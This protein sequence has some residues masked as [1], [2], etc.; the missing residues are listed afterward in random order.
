MTVIKELAIPEANIKTRWEEP[1]VSSAINRI[2]SALPRGVY[3]GFEVTQKATPGSGVK[4]NILAGR[5][6]FLLHQDI[7]GGHKTSVRYAVD[8]EVDFTVSLFTPGTTYF[9][10]VDVTYAVLS[11]TVGAIF[12]GEAADLASAPN[13]VPI[14]RFNSADA[15]ITNAEIWSS[16]SAT[17]APA[18]PS[19]FL[20]PHP[21][22]SEDNPYGFINELEYLRLPTQDQKDAMDGAASPSA[23]NPFATEDGLNKGAFSYV[24]SDGTV[25]HDGDFDGVNALIQALDAVESDGGGAIYV[26]RGNYTL[27]G[28]PGKTYTKPI[29][30]YCEG[31]PGTPSSNRCLLTLDHTNSVYGLTFTGMVDIRHLEIVRGAA[32][33]LAVSFQDKVF[34]E[35]LIVSGG[36]VQYIGCTG[37]VTGGLVDECSI[38]GIPLPGLDIN[39]VSYVASGGT[40]VTVQGNC[41]GATFSGCVFDGTNGGTSNGG[42]ISQ[43]GGSGFSQGS[44]SQ[45]TFYSRGDFA[46]MSIGNTIANSSFRDCVV[47]IFTPR[48]GA[49]D[50]ASFKLVNAQGSITVSGLTINVLYS[51]AVVSPLFGVDTN[52]DSGTQANLDLSGIRLVG[53]ANQVNHSGGKALYYIETDINSSEESVS[54]VSRAVKITGFRGGPTSYD[55][56]SLVAIGCVT[57][58]N[59][60][61]STFLFDDLS[62]SGLDNTDPAANSYLAGFRTYGGEI[63]A[64]VTIRTSVMDGFELADPTGGDGFYIGIRQDNTNYINSPGFLNV[65]DSPVQGWL[66]HDIHVDIPDV[67][68]DF[69]P[70]K[71]DG[72]RNKGIDAALTQGAERI[73]TNSNRLQVVNCRFDADGEDTS[74]VKWLYVEDRVSALGM[75]CNIG[76]NTVRMSGGAHDAVYIE[77]GIPPCVLTGNTGVGRINVAEADDHIGIGDISVGDKNIN[78]LAVLLR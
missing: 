68:T 32:G 71:L 36:N 66:E 67:G 35:N 27:T 53:N 57:S 12:M 24:V 30:I 34:T 11:S 76:G 74:A 16:A 64:N 75:D 17:N 20:S 26:R 9:V 8:F 1:Y 62:I 46:A 65:E 21:D 42:G 6:S 41:I 58:V 61:L 54:A 51:G 13:A 2:M 29:H 31:G 59:S 18:T 69:C 56:S 37:S 47:N 72:V 55:R 19:D 43:A 7:D 50:E 33:T 38:N 5:D 63:D 44:F 52:P 10:W 25:S 78:T 39:S 3:W 60:G 48:S 70:M 49:S 15:T 23:A 4:I 45:C 28:A 73:K 40:P 14:A 77:T 22:D